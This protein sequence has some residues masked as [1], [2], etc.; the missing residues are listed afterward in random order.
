VLTAAQAAQVQ[1]MQRFGGQ[2]DAN[3]S[4]A[5]RLRANFS[6][7]ETAI[8]TLLLPA[9][10]QIVEAA[11]RWISNAHNQKMIMDTLKTVIADVSTAFGVL[12]SIIQT[13]DSVTGGFGNTVKI[14]IGLAV[15]AKIAAWSGALRALIVRLVAAAAAEDALAAGAVAASAAAVPAFAAIGAAALAALPELAAL[16]SALVGVYLAYKGAQ[17]ILRGKHGP[18]PNYHK[19]LHGG[20]QLGTGGNNGPT[21]R[22]IGGSVLAG[23]PYLVGERGMELFVPRSSGTIVPNHQLGGGGGGNVIFQ[24]GAVVVHGSADAAF[25]K[26]LAGELA[27]Q[28]RGGRVPAFQQA[29]AAI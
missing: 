29:I 19:G 4:A 1:I 17:V 21:G 9:F 26:T 5:D 20:P 13:V 8:G 28:L 25:A 23:M 16:A 6:N 18:P 24:P 3:T 15:A 11:D 7:L 12:K 10:N 14:V 27:T 22:A 2:A